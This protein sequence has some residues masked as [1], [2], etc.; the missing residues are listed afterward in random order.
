MPQGHGSHAALVTSVVLPLRFIF[1][2][3]CIW[4]AFFDLV[5]TVFSPSDNNR[6]LMENASDMSQS[7][8]HQVRHDCQSRDIFPTTLLENTCFFLM[9]CGYLKQVKGYFFVLLFSTYSF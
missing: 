7:C 1:L 3:N 8:I 5:K 4:K 9:N 6:L 2:F